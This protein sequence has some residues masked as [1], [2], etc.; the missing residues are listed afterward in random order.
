MWEREV[1]LSMFRRSL[2]PLLASFGLAVGFFLLP[3]PGQADQWTDLTRR[4]E[5][6]RQQID[7]GEATDELRQKMATLLRIRSTQPDLAADERLGYLQEALEFAPDDERLAYELARAGYEVGD[8]NLAYE[9][10]QR[11]LALAPEDFHNQ[12]LA[13]FICRSLLRYDEAVGFLEKARDLKPDH[14]P[15]LIS[16]G[17]TYAELRQ[18]DRAIDVWET[19]LTMRPTSEEAAE[20]RE[21][22]DKAQRQEAATGGGDAMESHRFVVQFSGPTR[23]DLAA[24]ALDTLE[25]VF[26]CVAGELQVKPEGKVIVVFYRQADFHQVNDGQAWVGGYAQNLRIGVPYEDGPLDGP[27]IKSL[28]AHELTHV[29]VNVLTNRNH[30]TWLTEGLAEYYEAKVRYGDGFA[31]HPADRHLF[32]TKFKTR[33]SFPRLNAIDLN[34][35]TKGNDEEISLKYIHSKVAVAFLLQRFGLPALLEIFQVLA[36]GRPIEEAIES[37]T[38]RTM[39]D[40]EAELTEFIR[41]E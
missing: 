40:F 7:R 41:A 2:L 14:V 33:P 1:R 28:F 25:E 38:G 21:R 37:G 35:K 8:A 12:L 29:L 36:R 13:G 19:A 3:I 34:M 39:S 4:I 10:I 31:F 24:M 30:P 9:H 6:L 22:I 26:D 5:A 17:R 27:R 18:F 11:A 15:T 16:L 23:D 32:E 20:L